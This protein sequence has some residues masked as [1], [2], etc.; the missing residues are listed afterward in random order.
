MMIE[1]HFEKM[2]F[3][4]KNYIKITKFILK[5]NDFLS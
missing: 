1:I 2:I 3:Y 5:K 4:F